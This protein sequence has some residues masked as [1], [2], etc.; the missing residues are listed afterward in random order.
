M[1]TTQTK[2]TE[3]M[4]TTVI[5]SQRGN[6]YIST[7]SGKFGGGHSGAQAGET[8]GAAAAHAAEMMIRYAQSNKEGG[9]LM[10]PPDVLMLVPAHL[11]SIA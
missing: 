6:H 5:I 1:I 9:D 4:R 11:V 7:V 2:E 3:T 8:P 10:A